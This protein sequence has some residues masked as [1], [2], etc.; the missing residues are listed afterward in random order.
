MTLNRF[1][2]EWNNTTVSPYFLDLLNHREIS[3]QIAILFGGRTSIPTG[4]IN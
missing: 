2:R 4:L 1:Q 3:N